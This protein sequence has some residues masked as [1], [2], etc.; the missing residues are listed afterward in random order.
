MLFLSVSFCVWA[1]FQIPPHRSVMFAIKLGKIG[2]ARINMYFFAHA[3]ADVLEGWFFQHF[4]G[5]EISWGSAK[6]NHQHPTNRCRVICWKWQ[7][8]D[9]RH[10]CRGRV[11]GGIC[12]TKVEFYF[13]WLKQHWSYPQKCQK[14]SQLSSCIIRLTFRGRYNKQEGGAGKGKL[15]PFIQSDK[16]VVRLPP[17]GIK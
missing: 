12:S 4:I 10:Q 5:I 11:V 14:W 3:R 13:G 7:S 16:N 9:S 8:L 17:K 15:L 2:Y 1:K 6:K